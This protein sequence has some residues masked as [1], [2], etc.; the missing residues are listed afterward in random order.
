MGW[1][2]YPKVSKDCSQEL[3]L[4]LEFEMVLHRGYMMQL[5]LM[6]LEISILSPGEPLISFTH[7][8]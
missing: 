1:R 2:Y 6:E 8:I 3:E 5:L 7:M 4:I